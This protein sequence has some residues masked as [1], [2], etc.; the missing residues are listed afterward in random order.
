MPGR[1]KNAPATAAEGT[2]AL[3]QEMV[4][5]LLSLVRSDQ[6]P[7]TAK[8]RAARTVLEELGRS[9]AP[10][11]SRPADEASIEELDQEIAAE[12]QRRAGAT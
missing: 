10:G 2:D 4:D 11:S 9:A 3:R 5:A 6:T 12:L 7:P 1:K 8:E